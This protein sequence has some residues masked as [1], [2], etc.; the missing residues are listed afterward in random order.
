M[1]R[2][3]TKVRSGDPTPVTGGVKTPA[4][5]LMPVV[6][7]D[8]AAP[9]SPLDKHLLRLLTLHK[10]LSARFTTVDLTKMDDAAKRSLLTDIQELLNIE[11]AS[12]PGRRGTEPGPPSGDSA[13]TQLSTDPE[14]AAVVKAWP[15]LP[16][17]VKAGILA[18][19][20]A[21]GPG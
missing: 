20:K 18:M 9:A 12:L 3:Q 19:V 5:L 7:P 6:D 16:S 13:S 2:A 8:A 21:T 4:R 14:L 11:H 1:S 15:G 10:D 17:V